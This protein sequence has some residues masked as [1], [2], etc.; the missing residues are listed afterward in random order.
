[1][2]AEEVFAKIEE[3]NQK[4]LIILDL[5]HCKISTNACMFLKTGISKNTTINFL[6][7][8]GFEI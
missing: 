8:S 6:N 2:I 3:V 4:E 1:M 5:S 7:L